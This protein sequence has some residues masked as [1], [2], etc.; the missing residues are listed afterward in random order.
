ME[1]ELSEKRRSMLRNFSGRRRKK[2]KIRKNDQGGS[3]EEHEEVRLNL[4][5]GYGKWNLLSPVGEE[6]IKQ[7]L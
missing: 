5:E 2:I 3:G 7:D 1:G 4:E 6:S